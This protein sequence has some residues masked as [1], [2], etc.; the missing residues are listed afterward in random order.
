LIFTWFLQLVRFATSS[1]LVPDARQR[2]GTD[3]PEEVNRR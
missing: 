3:D 2:E 1:P